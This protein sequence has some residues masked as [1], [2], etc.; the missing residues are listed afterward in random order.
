[1]NNKNH[2]EELEKRIKHIKEEPIRNWI[3]GISKKLKIRKIENKIKSLK[4]II[5][6]NNR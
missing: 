2:I 6:G 5:N 3:H 1:M 4:K